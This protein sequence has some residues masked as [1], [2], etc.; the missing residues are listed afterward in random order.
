MWRLPDP[1]SEDDLEVAHL[2][3]KVGEQLR[4]EQLQIPNTIPIGAKASEDGKMLTDE[5]VSNFVSDTLSD[6]RV[7]ERL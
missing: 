2:F 3:R 6:D 7:G 5:S 1:E 4:S